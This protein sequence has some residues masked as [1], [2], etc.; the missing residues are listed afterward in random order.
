MKGVTDGL[1]Y[2]QR[3]RGLRSDVELARGAQE[4]IHDPG[5]RCGEPRIALRELCARRQLRE[6]LTRPVTGLSFAREDAY[7]ADC[8]MSMLAIVIPARKSPARLDKTMLSA[9]CKTG[10]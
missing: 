3:E 6:T 7:E 1:S 8:G 10:R 5:D 9:K 2:E 4:R